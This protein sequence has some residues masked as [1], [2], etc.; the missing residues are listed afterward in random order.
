MIGVA[1]LL[2]GA[3]IGAAFLYVERIDDAT[4]KRVALLYGACTRTPQI[5]E[6][7]DDVEFLGCVGKVKRYMARRHINTSLERRFPFLGPVLIQPR[8]RP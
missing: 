5:E 1:L 6:E 2:Y 8:F 4:A 7:K 3:Y